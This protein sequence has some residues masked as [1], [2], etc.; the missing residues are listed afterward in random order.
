MK[1]SKRY[2]TTIIAGLILAALAGLSVFKGME[3]LASACVAG[4]MTILTT[5]IW[6]ETKRPSNQNT[7]EN[8][9]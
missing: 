3:G 7:N 2:I 6:G 9:K 4:I 8:E 5:Y 1:F